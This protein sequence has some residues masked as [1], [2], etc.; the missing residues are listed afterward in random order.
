MSLIIIFSV[1]LITLFLLNYTIYWTV[2]IRTEDKNSRFL[3]NYK[4]IFPYIWLISIIIIPIINSSFLEPFF[5]ENVSYF[6]Q[7]WVWFVLLSF[8]FIAVAIRIYSQVKKV[9]EQKIEDGKQIELINQSVYKIIRHPLYLSRL[10]IFLG[11]TFICDSV[12]G[13]IFSPILVLL[14][15]INCGLKEKF[16][17]IPKFKTEYEKYAKKTPH[18]VIPIPYNYLLYIIGAIILYIGFLNFDFIF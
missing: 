8:I 10:L 5:S 9:S 14:T 17:Y 6:R 4:K 3:H 11:I 18:K 16:V 12:F 7:Y 15:E 1:I 13:I 2:F